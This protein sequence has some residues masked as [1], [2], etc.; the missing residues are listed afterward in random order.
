MSQDQ[1]VLAVN[2]PEVGYLNIR[3]SR[4]PARTGHPCQRSSGVGA[5]EPETWCAKRW[6]NR[7]S[8]QGAAAGRQVVMRRPGTSSSPR[9]RDAG[10]AAAQTVVVNSPEVPL[11]V[12]SGRAC[13]IRSCASADGTVLRCWKPPKQFKPKSGN[14]GS[15]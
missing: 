8:A 5:V 3:S 12:R 1:L 15:G 11:K 9:R 14:R 10:P 2:S 13:R 6:G 4:L 7:A